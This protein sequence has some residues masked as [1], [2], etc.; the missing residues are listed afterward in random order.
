MSPSLKLQ[1]GEKTNNNQQSINA[2]ISSTPLTT[3]HTHTVQKELTIDTSLASE[4]RYGHFSKEH[5]PSNH[6]LKSNLTKSI[7]AISPFFIIFE[8]LGVLIVLISLQKIQT[9]HNIFIKHQR[10]DIPYTTHYYKYAH[11]SNSTAVLH[12]TRTRSIP[13]ARRR[14]QGSIGIGVGIRFGAPSQSYGCIQAFLEV[15]WVETTR[16]SL[17]GSLR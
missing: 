13:F 4:L 1:V 14:F 17:P 3:L 2:A 10:I 6:T 8:I 12:S 15:Y 11:S 5:L 16:I 9:Q 7:I